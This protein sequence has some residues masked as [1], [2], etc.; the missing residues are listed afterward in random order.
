MVDGNKLGDVGFKYLGVP[1]SQMD[2]Q[3]FVEKCLAD[4]G[5]KMDL[6]GSNAWFRE[7]NKNGV[8]L[9]PEECVRQLGCVPKGAFL[10]I[11]ER[12]GKEPEKYKP[13][14]LGNA[15][16]IGLCTIPRGEGAIHSSASR[17]CVAE[18][19]FKQ[20]TINGG[21]NRVGLWNRVAYDY[22]EGGT[23][24]PEP[25]PEPQPERTAIVGNVPSGSR[26]DVNL[27]K[28]PSQNGKL[29]ERVPCGERVEVLADDG[30]WA[31]VRWKGYTGFMM[32]QFLIFEEADLDPEPEPLEL[33]EKLYYVTIHDLPKALADEIAAKY[34]GSVKEERG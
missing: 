3:A 7:V 2:C 9:T 29:I 24:A 34:G 5:L 18:S 6:A 27:R 22:G 10:F 33:D 28:T 13:D 21:W 16:H 23:P 4:C 12:D 25:E 26:Q 15:S 31:K 17:G 14:G 20:K 1:Y 19:K 8:I 11:L 32:E 30:E